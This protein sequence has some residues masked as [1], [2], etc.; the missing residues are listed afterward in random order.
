LLGAEANATGYANTSG[1]SS[2]AV[3]PVVTPGTT[4]LNVTVTPLSTAVLEGGTTSTITVV[5]VNSSSGVPVPGAQVT[6]ALSSA[7]YGSFSASRELTGSNGQAN[8]TFTAGSTAGTVLGSFS[9][10]LSGALGGSASMALAVEPPGTYTPL[11]KLDARAQTR[12]S[13]GA[14]VLF[15]LHGYVVNSSTGVLLGPAVGARVTASIVTGQGNLSALTA[16]LNASGENSTLSVTTGVASTAYL[17]EVSFTASLAGEFAG[18]V[19]SVAVVPPLLSASVTLSSVTVKTGAVGSLVVLVTSGGQ[20]VGGATVS[21]SPAY[22]SAVT[23]TN[24]S[25]ITGPSGQVTFPFK[26]GSQG[27]QAVAFSI[28]VTKAGFSPGYNS[29]TLYI[30]SPTGNPSPLNSPSAFLGLSALDWGLVAIILLLLLAL[31][32]VFTRRNRSLPKDVSKPSDEGSSGEALSSSSGAGPK[33]PSAGE[34]A[35]GAAA[36]VSA[37]PASGGAE[38]PSSPD[39]GSPEIPTPTEG[40]APEPS[41]EAASVEAP[42]PANSGAMEGAPLSDTSVASAQ[43]MDVSENESAGTDGPEG[44]V[45]EKSVAPE[46]WEEEPPAETDKDGSSADTSGGS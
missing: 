16:V 4:L 17:L 44:P 36:V 42:E 2:L 45:P 14:P 15:T 30:T 33:P 18:N 23:L 19:T 6:T 24:T 26:A 13:P 20:G 38:M 9:A 43:K 8:F 37:T 3:T 25:G 22:L 31:I 7:G 39:P 28:S 27:G 32:A 34:E 12:A 35:L 46:E 21:I 40:A 10:T 11:L 1:W 41:P 5:V 29:T